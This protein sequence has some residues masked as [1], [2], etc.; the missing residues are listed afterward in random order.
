MGGSSSVT[1]VTLRRMP[2]SARESVQ[3]WPRGAGKECLLRGEQA[4]GQPRCTGA[5]Y[6]LTPIPNDQVRPTAPCA[7]ARL[8]RSVG[9]L[10]VR[11]AH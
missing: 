2:M 10:G 8:D 4:A 11:T 7:G 6:D 3:T 5:W 1:A 9:D